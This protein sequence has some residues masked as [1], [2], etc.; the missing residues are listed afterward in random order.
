MKRKVKYPAV[1]D[2][3]DYVTRY[4]DEKKTDEVVIRDG[5][6]EYWGMNDFVNYDNLGNVISVTRKISAVVRDRLTGNC[7]VVLAH[8]VKFV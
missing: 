4:N 5:F 8:D 6:L 7:F 3:G 2:N 1:N